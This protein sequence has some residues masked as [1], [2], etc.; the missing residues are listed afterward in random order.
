MLIER[1][2]F[3]IRTVKVLFQD[4]LEELKKSGRYSS[5]VAMSYNKMDVPG[6]VR[7]EKTTGLI[8]LHQSEDDIFKQFNDTTRNE[9]RKTLKDQDVSIRAG[10]EISAEVYQL[11]RTFEFSQGRVPVTLRELESCLSFE[12]YREGDLLSVITILHEKPHIRIRSIFSKRLQVEDK[13]I[14]KHIS[15]ATRRA[16]WEICCWGKNQGYST[17][18]LASINLTNP[19]TASITKFKMSFGP[20][21]VPEYTYTYK[22]AG[23]RVFEG[24]ARLRARLRIITA[25]LMRH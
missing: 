3:G 4:N 7:T 17:F 5:I 9:I 20:K 10:V 11:Y 2:Q 14:Y 1:T 13:E 19:K 12:V 21:I 25:R 15:N 24:V 18:D 16:L 8:D 22:T 6:F 23:F